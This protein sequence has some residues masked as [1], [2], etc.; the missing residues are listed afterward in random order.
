M[1]LL[2]R[3]TN[4]ANLALKSPVFSIDNS[5]EITNNATILKSKIQLWISLISVLPLLSTYKS[6]FVAFG[7]MMMIRGLLFLAS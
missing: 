6:R 7:I 3:V 5:I 1:K 4:N 2:K